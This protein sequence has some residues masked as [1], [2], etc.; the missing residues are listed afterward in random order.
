MI[1]ASLATMTVGGTGSNQYEKSNSPNSD[2][3]KSNVDA[4][5]TLKEWL[6]L[7]RVILL[8]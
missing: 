5:K 4:A 1:A 8:T 7:L 2:D 3:K 6:S